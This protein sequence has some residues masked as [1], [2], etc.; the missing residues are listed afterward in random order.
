MA[1]KNSN[2]RFDAFNQLRETTGP[3]G[4]ITSYSYNGD[5]L[6]TSKDVD[7]NITG[8]TWDGGDIVLE[9]NGDTMAKAAN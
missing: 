4:R 9:T 8:F 7:G 2:F 1:E 3:D 6:R 5:G